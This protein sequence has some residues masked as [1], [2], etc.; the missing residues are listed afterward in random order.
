MCTNKYYPKRGK[1]LKL[2]FLKMKTNKYIN[3]KK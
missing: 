3:E 1:K 2:G